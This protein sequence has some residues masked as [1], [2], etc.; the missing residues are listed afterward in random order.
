MVTTT[1]FKVPNIKLLLGNNK[2]TGVIFIKK[3]TQIETDKSL[4]GQMQSI[5]LSEES[6]YE[7]L[8]LY[9]SCAVSP[10]FKSYLRESSK[11]SDS[12]DFSGDKMAPSV[13]KKLVELEMGLLHLQQNVDIPEIQLTAHPSVQHIIR[14]CA[15]QGR[16]ARVQDMGS[17]V[18]DSTYLNTLQNLVNRWIKEI[19]KVLYSVFGL[20]YLPIKLGNTNGTRPIGRH[21]TAGSQ[22]LA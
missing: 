18:D 3:G 13:E 16:R 12:R 1:K 20:Y 14:T 7:T 21:R 5:T 15:E 11:A 9:L 8:H 6:P 10:F 4:P 22:F 2:A 19:Q 17:K